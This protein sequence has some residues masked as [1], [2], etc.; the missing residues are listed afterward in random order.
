MVKFSQPPPPKKTLLPLIH[1]PAVAPIENF[2]IQEY[3]HY[4]DLSKAFDLLPKPI[5]TNR[6]TLTGFNTNHEKE[7]FVRLVINHL[8]DFDQ[9]R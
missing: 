9:E 7:R 6:C 3:F 5:H 8:H 4:L 1:Q 2:M